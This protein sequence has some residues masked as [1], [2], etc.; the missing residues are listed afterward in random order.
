MKKTI[1][2]VILILLLSLILQLCSCGWL[3]FE[4]PNMEET[5]SFVSKNLKEILLI[6][7][8]L[9]DFGNIDVVIKNKYGDM[10]IGWKKEETVE[11]DEVRDA[12]R[13]LWKKGCLEI[14]K[15]FKNNAIIYQIWRRTIGHVQGGFVY[16]IDTTMLPDIQFLTELRPLTRDGWY[17]YNAEY[18]KWRSGKRPGD[19]SE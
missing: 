17:Y 5:D 9:L 6:N 15:D 1:L 8:Y 7:D 10:L 2:A 11:N 3:I 14:Y 12:I 18:E 19:P 4:T 16:A 13:S